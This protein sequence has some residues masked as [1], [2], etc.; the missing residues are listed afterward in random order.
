MRDDICLLW[1]HL[2]C[3]F[4]E[5]LQT[6]QATID[7]KELGVDI[8]R[9]G[10][11]KTALFVKLHLLPI[12]AHLGV[13]RVSCDQSSSL[14]GAGYSFGYQASS[15]LTERA[16]VPFLCEEFHVSCEFGHVRLVLFSLPC[17]FFV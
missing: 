4:H 11:S 8:S 7:I 9:D 17:P 3:K 16:S 13:A 2:I 14:S 10:G 5:L 6:S 12:V 15:T 1:I